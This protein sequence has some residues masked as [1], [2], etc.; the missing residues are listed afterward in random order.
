M[1]TYEQSPLDQ[2]AARKDRDAGIE[3]IRQRAADSA[4][5]DGLIKRLLSRYRRISA[6]DVRGTA[7]KEGHAI[8]HSNCVGAA[9]NTLA[10]QGYCVCVGHV[11][12]KAKAARGR[13]IKVW[14]R[15]DIAQKENVNG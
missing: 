4:Y 7:H 9:F 13:T 10:R 15:S 12:S 8:S 2:Q 6:D 1:A 3:S 14:S 11:Q 5:L